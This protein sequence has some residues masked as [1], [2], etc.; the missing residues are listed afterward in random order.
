MKN[1]IVITLLF[2]ST[3]GLSFASDDQVL[4]LGL[5]NTVDIS[6]EV[7]KIDQNY[8]RDVASE[9]NEKEVLTPTIEFWKFE[10]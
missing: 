4:E 3:L 10:K 7:I 9:E 2:L 1:L 6:D 5:P 8:I